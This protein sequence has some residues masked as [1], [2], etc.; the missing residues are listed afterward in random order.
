MTVDRGDLEQ[1][2]TVLNGKPFIE[3][4]EVGQFLRKYGSDQPR[5]VGVL[6]QAFVFV[7][8]V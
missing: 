4:A 7:S 6:D 5:N 1:V 8:E 3:V 2:E